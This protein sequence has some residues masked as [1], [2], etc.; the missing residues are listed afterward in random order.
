MS[1][2]TLIT[3][4]T[5]TLVGGSTTSLL[6]ITLSQPT[7]PTPPVDAVIDQHD[8][9]TAGGLAAGNKVATINFNSTAQVPVQILYD[10]VLFRQGLVVKSSAACT[11]VV[12]SE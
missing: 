3:D 6:S 11:V 7:S 1:K 9:S 10:G 4:T 12:E 8:V 2:L 5:A